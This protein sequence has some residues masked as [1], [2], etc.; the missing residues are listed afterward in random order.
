MQSHRVMLIKREKGIQVI[1]HRHF[2]CLY[3]IS[4]H[5]FGVMWIRI[6][7]PGSLG[8]WCMYIKGTSESTLVTDS[9][10][11]LMQKI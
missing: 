6:S 1:L 9:L 7:D 8:S 4:V 2:P 10:V 11:S 5:S 3:T